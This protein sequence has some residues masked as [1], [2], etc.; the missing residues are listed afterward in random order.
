M[1]SAKAPP[2]PQTAREIFDGLDVD[3]GGSISPEE[4][5][6][7]L[8]KCELFLLAFFS[9]LFVARFSPDSGEML[10]NFS[11]F[12]HRFLL[13]FTQKME[14][15]RARDHAGGAV[16]LGGQARRGRQRHS[17]RA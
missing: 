4:L 17:V 5:G 13:T 10:P 14:Q 7:G 11:R 8:A 9:S 6:M 16:P 15:A 2:K 3:G 1:R 12:P